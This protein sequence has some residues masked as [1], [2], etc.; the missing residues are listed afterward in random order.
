MSLSTVT[1]NIAAGAGAVTKHDTTPNVWS[2]LYVGSG[3][4][5]AL[6]T[7]TGDNI[8]LVNVPSGSFVWVRTSL[9]KATNS[10]ASDIVGFK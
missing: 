6:T 9:V 8:T 7:E 2:Y 1:Q 3:G 10:T 5:L 4:N